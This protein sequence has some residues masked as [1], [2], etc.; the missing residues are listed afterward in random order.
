VLHRV[1]VGEHTA[2]ELARE[3]DPE[4]QIDRAQPGRVVDEVVARK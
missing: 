2:Q 3:E 1:A 4:R